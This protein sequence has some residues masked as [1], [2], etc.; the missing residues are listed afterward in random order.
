MEESSQIAN[1]AEVVSAA[2]GRFIWPV[3]GDIISGFGVIG[4]GRKND[5]IDI[6][7]AQGASVHAAAAGN[8]V[9]AGNQVPGFGNLVLVKHTDGWVTA[10]AHLDKISV[11][12]RQM[13]TQGQELGLVGDTGGVR[14][15][16][17]HFEVRYAPSA[18]DKAKPLDPQLVLPK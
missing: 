9:Y 8:V 3:R 5:G 10:Y 14:E 16:Q 4:I 13:V 2:Q 17:L 7:A 12:M 18:A 6:R 1:Q 11:Q 15:P